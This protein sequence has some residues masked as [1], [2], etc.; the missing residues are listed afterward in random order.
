MATS[1]LDYLELAR[2]HEISRDALV[3]NID[4]HVKVEVDNYWSKHAFTEFM[5]RQENIKSVGGAE[6]TVP[7][8]LGPAN[9]GGTFRGNSKLRN[10]PKDHRD[11]V[12]M[13]WSNY[14]A[15]LS[16][17]YDQQ[18]EN[19]G[20][21]A[22]FD[23]AEGDVKS[24][25]E[26]IA[27][28]FGYVLWDNGTRDYGDGVINGLTGL[29]AAVDDGTTYPTYAG[30]TWIASISVPAGSPDYSK[31]AANLYA[32][33]G[34]IDLSDIEAANILCADGSSQDEEM[35]NLYV[36][37]KAIYRD[38]KKQA[39]A[40]TFGKPEQ[41]ADWPH[42]RHFSWDG[43]MIIY[44]SFCPAGEMYGL[45]TKYWKLEVHSKGHFVRPGWLRPVDQMAEV[46]YIVLKTRL[47]C[48]KRKAQVKWTGITNGL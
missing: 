36:T 7:I 32:S 24:A 18:T 43:S 3:A 30:V 20:A 33:A 26:T 44:D 22:L 2:P 14:Y 45:T 34:Y 6:V 1:R 17:N 39:S 47:Y 4:A 8:N 9:T 15:A 29:P 41:I 37:T 27:E 48:T 38:L 10:F 46:D 11:M 19:M 5:Q 21:E 23:L 40:K 35:P 13:P 28:N 25:F 16:R 12:K 31:W 42:T